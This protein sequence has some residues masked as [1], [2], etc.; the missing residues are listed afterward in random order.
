MANAK[1]KK[2]QYKGSSKVISYLVTV[3]NWLLDN[4]GGG[5]S[6]V[7]VTPIVSTG[8][9]IAEITVDGTTYDIYAPTGGTTLPFD[10]E[11]D[12]TDNGINIIYPSSGGG[13]GG[14]ATSYG[15]SISGNTLSI[16]P[17]GGQSSV[18]LPSMS[19]D[20]TLSS[21]S[22]NAVQNKVI[23]A[24]ISEVETELSNVNTKIES[25]VNAELYEYLNFTGSGY[26]VLDSFTVE[27]DYK[28]TVDF[29][30]PTY[31]H[32]M[33]VIGRD[34]AGSSYFHL[35][36]YGD[37]WWASE[38]ASESS[39]SE[40]LTGRHTWICNNGGYNTFDGDNVQNYTPTSVAEHLTIGTSQGSNTNYLQGRI[41][42]YKIESISTG[43]VLLNLK[44]VKITASGIILKMGLYD[45]VSG[46]VYEA[47]GTSVGG[48]HS[49][50]QS[51]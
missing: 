21:T 13:G 49:S 2:L 40:S 28:V 46:R 31:I 3:A 33:G 23:T 27:S 18:S 4:G 51:V 37:T 43:D 24:K 42:S 11:I 32:N 50:L 47:S 45:E 30:I 14:S 17:N 29:E 5:G 16:V 19:I 22:E 36:E 44:P 41:Y 12:E 25:M 10:F 20:S 26:I 38:G 9:K 35:T 34:T 1:P 48:T 39:F 6:D 7:N 8:T 15:L